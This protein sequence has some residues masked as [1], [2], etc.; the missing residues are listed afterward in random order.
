MEGGRG[1]R[2]REVRREERERENVCL[3]V[4]QVTNNRLPVGFSADT[5]ERPTSGFHRRDTP[6]RLKGSR[7]RSEV[8]GQDA[9]DKLRQMIAQNPA[10]VQPVAPSLTS[11]PSA[12]NSVP[13]AQALTSSEESLSSE[14]L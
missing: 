1:A 8:N 9:S 2:G 7:V 5:A 10:L 3:Y 11:M 13:T 4:Y 12:R 6:H 14:V